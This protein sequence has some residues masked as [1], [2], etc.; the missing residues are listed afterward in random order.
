M[1]TA[2][3]RGY[4]RIATEEAWCTPEL[5]QRFQRL[6]DEGQHGDP[7][8]ANLWGFFAKSDS[9][10]AR[11]LYE[12]IQDL[13]SRRLADMDASGV[14]MQ[15]LMLTAPGVQMFDPATA[16]S[17]ATSTND[18]LA[19]TI[20]RHPQR[21]AGLAAFAPHA[22]DAAAAEIERGVK[23]LGLK[24]ALVNSHTQGRYM[25]DEFFWPIFEACEALDVPLYIHPNSPSPQ[26]V[27]PF[28]SRCLDAAIWGFQAETGLHA[29]RLL[30]SGLF[31]RFPKLKIVLG[32]LGEGLPFWLSRIDFMHAGI[33]RS[34]R[35]EGAK[36]L[37]RKPSEYLRENFYYT[38]SGM[39]WEPAVTFVQQQMGFDRVMYAMDYPYQFEPSE[40]TAMDHLPLTLEQKRQFFQTNAERIFK[41]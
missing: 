21:F 39:C 31:D 9:P 33:V 28:L 3:S 29:L 16:C 23:K 30:V 13:E 10:R 24:G 5:M 20:A 4:K 37:K 41:L 2:E 25:D 32:H 34:G 22:P 18:Q 1:D 27:E 36:P 17:L 35:S 12:R 38:S 19:E 26:M 11:G 14:D 6:L 8:F 7:G 40:V 15:L